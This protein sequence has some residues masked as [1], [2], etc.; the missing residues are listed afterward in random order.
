MDWYQDYQVKNEADGAVLTIF[1]N[2]NSEE[3]ALEFLGNSKEK[4]LGLRDRV[5]DLVAERFSGVKIKTV[6]LMLGTV[7]V[8]VIPLSAGL[9]AKAAEPSFASVSQEYATGTV[10][11]SS[12]RVRSGPGTGYGIL[13]TLY[14]GNRVSLLGGSGG[15]Y[16]VLLTDGTSGWVSG[17]YIA[18]DTAPLAIDGVVTAS[19]LNVR[20]GPGTG[21]T[22]LHVLWQGN[23]VTVTGQSG[24]WYRL[25]LADGRTGWVS[26]N[27]LRPENDSSQ[28]K[29]DTVV[30]TA[31]SLIGTPYVW[32]G[33]SP[34]EGGFDCSGLTQ[35]VYG[36]VGISLP[37]ISSDQATQGVPVGRTSL[38]PGD[39]V[40]FSFGANGIIDHVGIYIG[41]GQMIHSPKTGDTVKTTDITTSY[42]QTRF[43]T[44][45]RLIE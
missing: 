16:H 22:V 12:L 9:T 45:R 19:K 17:D 2:E 25:R 43:V 33:E 3:F 24:D 21:F 40:F 6:K 13:H 31:K 18:V 10:T 11:A 42:W 35:Y 4:V 29:R 36:K 26:K 38:I 5:N 39:L 20:S 8:A 34:A 14:N 23:R 41:N 37:R 32:G 28:Q 1:L 44:A 30:S 7:L 15:W 27:Y